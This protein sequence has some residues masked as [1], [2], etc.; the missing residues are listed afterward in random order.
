[1][2]SSSHSPKPRVVANG[3]GARVEIVGSQVRI[4]RNG[5]FGLLITLF[6]LGD[7]LSEKTIPIHRISSIEIVRTFAFVIF[8]I[9]YMRFSFPGSP[10]AK[11]SD[12][13]D[14]MLEHTVM[15]NLF[16]N[17][18]FYEMK[19]T[20]EREMEAIRRGDSDPDPG[21]GVVSPGPAAPAAPA[22]AARW[23]LTTRSRLQEASAWAVARAPGGKRGLATTLASLALLAGLGW[24]SSADFV[25]PPPEANADAAATRSRA[26]DGLFPFFNGGGNR[27][28]MWPGP[29]GVV[30]RAT[31]RARAYDEFLEVNR[32]MSD[33]L[34]RRLDARFRERLTM[35]LDPVFADVD[36]R[37]SEYGEWVFNWWTSYI[38]LVRGLSAIWSQV[39]DGTEQSLQ[40]VT[41]RVMA[42]EIKSR[43]V[44]IVLP[45]DSFR[46]ALSEAVARAVFEMNQD[47]RRGCDDL[48]ARFAAFLLENSTAVEFQTSANVWAADH[49]WQTRVAGNTYCSA[50]GRRLQAAS[51]EI[52]S[53]Y[54]RVFGVT[55][56][57][58]DVAIRITRPFVTTIVSAGLSASGIATVAVG[59]GIP[60]ALVATPAMAAVL[61]KSAFT[62]VD[63]M[64][65]ELDAALNRPNFEAAVRD[66]VQRS[67]TGFE[68]AAMRVVRQAMDHELV[69]MRGSPDQP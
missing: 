65:S 61:T 2:N 35:E 69:D 44:Q 22:A 59:I 30:Y 58:E 49:G 40:E 57:I 56:A 67:R 50:P 54:D 48:R 19:E 26:T 47:L 14:S 43:Y 41:E 15:M 52:E 33:G 39:A 24:I 66:A 21:D 3:M 5:L 4:K 6:G 20:I 12:W 42:D 62:L 13:R 10:E 37:I 68:Q 18:K 36:G 34:R 51:V 45:P 7:G 29:G 64:L 23:L 17:R 63:L 1:M 25:R 8:C 60:A 28:V 16:D 53:S 27:T 31:V 38:L 9:E 46:P 32:S 11:G 55:G